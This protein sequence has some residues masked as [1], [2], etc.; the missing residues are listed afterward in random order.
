MAVLRTSPLVLLCHTFPPTL[1]LC[2]GFSH[3][4][5]HLLVQGIVVWVEYL[6]QLF[7]TVLTF[8]EALYFITLLCGYLSDLFFHIVTILF[9]PQMGRGILFRVFLRQVGIPYLYVLPPAGVARRC[10]L[11]V[12]LCTVRDSEYLTPALSFGSSTHSVDN[13]KRRSG[14]TG[15]RGRVSTAAGLE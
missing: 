10:A 1:K 5:H 13:G 15:A 7:Q 12:L 4:V 11:Y 14:G 6:G 9:V 3:I 2:L 8:E